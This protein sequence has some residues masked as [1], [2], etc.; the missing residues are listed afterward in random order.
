ME[1]EHNRRVFYAEVADL[2]I[3]QIDIEIFLVNE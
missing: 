3:K 1:N 2:D